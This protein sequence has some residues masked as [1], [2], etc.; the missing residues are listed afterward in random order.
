MLMPSTSESSSRD[1]SPQPFATA[2]ASAQRLPTGATRSPQPVAAHAHS[3][4]L[5]Q[6]AMLQQRFG[7]QA[8]GGSSLTTPTPGESDF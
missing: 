7:F 1:A 5:Q 2:A 4:F 6:A 8:S 3:P